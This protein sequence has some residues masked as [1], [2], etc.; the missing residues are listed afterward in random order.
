MQLLS[1]LL[2]TKERFDEVDEESGYGKK[3]LGQDDG[4]VR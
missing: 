3:I 4:K 2:R 1:Y